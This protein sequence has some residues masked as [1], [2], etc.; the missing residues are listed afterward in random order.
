MFAKRVGDFGEEIALKF[1]QD[2]G[3]LLIE[4][5]Y[6]KKPYGELDLVVKKENKIYFVE[7]K[8]SEVDD[9]DEINNLKFLPIEHLDNR[10][11]KKFERIGEIYIKEK[12]LEDIEYHFLGIMV[13]LNINNKQAMV[14]I[15]DI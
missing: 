8:T 5:N 14:K 2:K 6:E 12:K 11:I 4:Q 15:I 3:F 7:V 9:L 1:L 13:Y 10:K